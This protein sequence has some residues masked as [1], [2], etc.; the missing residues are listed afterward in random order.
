VTPLDCIF[1]ILAAGV[2][3]LAWVCATNPR[4]WL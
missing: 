2:V 4:P 3:L 1:G